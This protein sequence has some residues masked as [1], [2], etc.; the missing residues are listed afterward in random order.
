M[1][2]SEPKIPQRWRTISAFRARPAVSVLFSEPKI[3][4]LVLLL[5]LLLTSSMRFSALQRAENSSTRRR[6]ASARRRA[7]VSVLFSEPKIPQLA[8]SSP[9]MITP[10]CFSALQRAENSS[11]PGAALTVMP[12]TLSF[13]ALQRAEN[14]STE[15]HSYAQRRQNVSV[16]F[17]EPKIP[18]P[19]QR[20]LMRRDG[21]DGRIEEFSAR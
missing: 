3:P 18:Q 5:M 17:S 16:L 21:G 13:S 2:F 6:S 15:L 19:F 7:S 14:S 11:T 12:P 4:Q 10:S 1:L 9:R 8:S 20:V